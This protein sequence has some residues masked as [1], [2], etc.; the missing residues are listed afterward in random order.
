VDSMPDE[1]GT[2]GAREPGA[3]RSMGM[4]SVAE[5]IVGASAATIAVVALTGVAPG[6]LLAVATIAAGSGLMLQG[7]TIAGRLSAMLEETFQGRAWSQELG[8]MTAEFLGGVTG[9]V[10]GVLALLGIHPLVLPPAAA[11]V[12]GSALIMGSGISARISMLV[13]ERAE[14]DRFARQ[15]ARQ[16]IAAAAGLRALIGIGA[17]V[18]GI[19]GLSGVSPVLVSLVAILAVGVSDLLSG[20]AVAGRLVNM[21]HG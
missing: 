5:G 1:A 14:P 19:L 20:T 12:L 3:Y 8:G 4:S 17:V 11:V 16:A 21:F 2:T 15:V 7:G 10:L 9:I 6:I 18:L 13:I